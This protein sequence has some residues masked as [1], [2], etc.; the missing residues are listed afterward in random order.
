MKF[1]QSYWKSDKDYRYVISEKDY[2]RLSILAGTDFDIKMIRIRVPTA[3]HDCEVLTV[4]AQYLDKKSGYAS[5]S[6]SQL[7]DTFYKVL[8][9]WKRSLVVNDFEKAPSCDAPMYEEALKKEKIKYV[10]YDTNEISDKENYYRITE[11]DWNKLHGVGEIADF[12]TKVYRLNR[13]HEVKDIVPVRVHYYDY[14]YG[15][16]CILLEDLH[17]SYQDKRN[18]IAEDFHKVETMED[19]TKDTKYQSNSGIENFQ[20][21]NKKDITKKVEDLLSMVHGAEDILEDIRKNNPDF[22]AGYKIEAGIS[23]ASVALQQCIDEKK[24]FRFGDLK[25]E[26]Y[27]KVDDV[28]SSATDVWFEKDSNEDDSIH[29]Y[30]PE[31]VNIDPLATEYYQYIV[32]VEILKGCEHY[33]TMV[34]DAKTWI[35]DP[36]FLGREQC[37]KDMAEYILTW[38]FK[39]REVEAYK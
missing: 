30:K 25:F 17:D 12:D 10:F 9:T 22:D 39:D 16:G 1:Y 31:F 14:E 11:K 5:I 18:L 32:V 3:L 26:G 19:D 7:N 20:G 23:R 8:G 29:I 37:L 2:A 27:K 15:T 38:G 35:A 33:K 21:Q 4:R 24:Y 28:A 34:L 36:E 13:K 6:L